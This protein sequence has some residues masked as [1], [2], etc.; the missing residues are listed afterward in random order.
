MIKKYL[1]IF[2]IIFACITVASGMDGTAESGDYLLN[3]ISFALRPKVGILENPEWHRDLVFEK[4]VESSSDGTIHRYHNPDM[5]LEIKLSEKKGLHAKAKQVEITAQYHQ[6][7]SIV[8]FRLETLFDEMVPESILRGAQAID[9]RNPELNKNLYSFTDRIMQYQFKEGALWFAASGYDGCTNSEWLAEDAIVF[10]HHSL[11]FA[12]RF[13]PA[14]AHFTLRT[15]ALK[16]K[17]GDRDYHSFLIFEEK[18]VVLNVMRWPAGKEAALV[19]TN[20]ADGEGLAKLYAVF[21]GSSNPDSPKYLKQGIIA[22]NIKMT[23]TVFGASKPVM[24]DAWRDLEAHDIKI[25]Y[26]TATPYADL[27]DVTYQNLVHDMDEYNIR[28]WIDHSWAQNPECFCVEGWDK[29]SPYYIMDAINDSKIDYVWLGDASYT[30]P[31]NS[32]TEPW[33]L[34]HKLYEFDD[35][36]RDVWFYGRTLMGTWE[37]QNFGFLTDFK[38]MMTAENLDQLIR[39]QGLCVVYT[40]FFYAEVEPYLP[41]YKS[42]P[43]GTMEI[44]PEVEERL[45]MLDFYQDNRGLWIDTLEE[46][47]DRMIATESLRISGVR[48]DANKGNTTIVLENASDFALEEIALHYEGRSFVISEIAPGE[49]Y[50]LALDDPTSGEAQE[51]EGYLEMIAKYSDGIFTFWHKHNSALPKLKIDIYNL[52]GQRVGGQEYM[53]GK[54]ELTLAMPGIASGV[55]LARVEIGGGY[56]KTMKLMVVK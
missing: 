25:G 11:H 39:E 40:H 30:N 20:D 55:Y 51:D 56:Q 3:G 17:A 15:D 53:Q 1:G 9:A 48:Q 28:S 24:A 16:R 52:R 8:D 10:Y 7:L 12:R 36:T 26:H 47:F 13:N 32:F 45:Q 42:M 37:I 35:L 2:A 22:N 50:S 38:T 41:F 5:E 54:R 27:S 44:R 43:D 21:F 46:V 18:P 49:S 33:R 14:T 4:S 29:D 6:E 34:P 19:I 23:N 31:M